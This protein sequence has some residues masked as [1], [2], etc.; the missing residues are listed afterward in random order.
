[1]KANKGAPGI[2]GMTVEDFPAFARE[3]WPRM[4]EGLNAANANEEI[5]G[6]ALRASGGGGT[7]CPPGRTGTGCSSHGGALRVYRHAEEAL[8]DKPGIKV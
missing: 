5:C 3:L 8:T 7:G 4:W 1:M 6:G 2:D